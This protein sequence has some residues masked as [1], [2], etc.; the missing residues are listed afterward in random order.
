M[1]VTGHF[2]LVSDQEWLSLRETLGL[3]PQQAEVV[4]HILRGKSDKQIARALGI[5]VPTVRTHMGRL[6]RKLDLNDRVELILH[7]FTRT[8]EHQQEHGDPEGD[9]NQV[10]AA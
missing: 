1:A 7:V 3:S 9:D 5:S 10:E 4:K 6:F 2:D 8:R